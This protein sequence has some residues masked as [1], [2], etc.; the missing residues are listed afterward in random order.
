LIEDLDGRP[1]FADDPA[2]INTGIG[3]PPLV[4]L[5]PYER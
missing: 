3:T 1:R 5:G 2:T 4:D